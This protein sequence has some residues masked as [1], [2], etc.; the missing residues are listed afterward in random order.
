FPQFILGYLG[1]PRRYHTYPAEFQ[2]LHVMSSAGAS[3][4]GIGY[5]LPLAYLLW[6]SRYAKKAGKNPWQAT[7]LEWITPS[8]PPKDNFEVTPIVRRDPYEYHREGTQDE[9]P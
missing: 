7:G 4:L 3:I 2:T 1:M 9:P 8:P 5:L 6:A